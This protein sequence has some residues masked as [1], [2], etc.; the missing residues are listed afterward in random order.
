[1]KAQTWPQVLAKTIDLGSGGL[2]PD[3]ISRPETKHSQKLSIWAR[4]FAAELRKCE[5]FSTD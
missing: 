4:T 3:L 2:G 1:M 5:P